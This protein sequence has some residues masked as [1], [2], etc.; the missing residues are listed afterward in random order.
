LSS[1]LVNFP[2]DIQ[3]KRF[4]TCV[5][6]CLCNKWLPQ[7]S[8]SVLWLLYAYPNV[9]ALFSCPLL[10]HHTSSS[11]PTC[12]IHVPWC[13]TLLISII[14]TCT[15]CTP[16]GT[17]VPWHHSFSR[18]FPIL[19]DPKSFQTTLNYFRPYDLMLYD[20]LVMCL[21]SLSRCRLIITTTIS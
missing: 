8:W 16:W 3:F 11:R 21:L 17:H 14:H 5:I 9:H 1:S 18:L 6:I 15:M 13:Y 12:H 4:T 10:I 7:H 19:L 2:L 20:F